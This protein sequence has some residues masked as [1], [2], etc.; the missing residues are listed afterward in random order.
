MTIVPPTDLTSRA[1]DAPSEPLPERM[2]A[3][4]PSWKDRAADARMLSIDG[5]GRLPSVVP[6]TI[7][8][9]TISWG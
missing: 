4:T 8:A 9:S 5:V 2:T 3:I 7:C 1:P 6:R